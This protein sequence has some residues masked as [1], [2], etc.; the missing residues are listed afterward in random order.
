MTKDRVLTE[1]RRVLNAEVAA[2]AAM[3]DAARDEATH[4]E[5][6]PENKYDTRALEA[7]YLAAGQGR[8]LLEL[9]QLAGWA[10]AAGG[11][12]ERCQ[13]GA[14]VVLDEDV[15]GEQTILLA[16]AGGVRV[17][18]ADTPVTVVSMRSPLGHALA[19]LEAGD[20]VQLRSPGGVRELEIVSVA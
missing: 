4:A 18:V 15:A 5:S 8:R 2:L 19:G 7:S 1:L 20:A 13:V 16:P 17:V 3:N 11:P 6:R 10:D 14:L 9:G 12:A